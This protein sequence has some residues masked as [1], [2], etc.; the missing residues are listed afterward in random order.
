MKET[1]I[2]KWCLVLMMAM[3]LFAILCVKSWDSD[4]TISLTFWKGKI[5]LSIDTN[6]LYA[7]GA[8]VGLMGA[9]NV[10]PKVFKKIPRK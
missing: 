8:I 4:M 2:K 6:L 1:E 3:F 10:L 7:V 9:I 5:Y